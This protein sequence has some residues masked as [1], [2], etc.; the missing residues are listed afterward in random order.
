MNRIDLITWSSF[1]RVSSVIGITACLCFSAGEGLRLT[2]LPELSLQREGTLSCTTPDYLG[3]PLNR[4]AQVQVQKLNKRQLRDCEIPP[5]SGASK[6]LFLPLP[7]LD[8][9]ER[10]TQVSSVSEAAPPG[11][12]PP[13]IS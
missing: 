8:D 11:R 5:A 12:S 4:P 6:M 13:L 2:P 9:D 10:S 1:V 3:G 7:Y